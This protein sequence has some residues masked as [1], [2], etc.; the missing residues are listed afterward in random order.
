MLVVVPVCNPIYV[1]G[2]GRRNP[3]SVGEKVRPLVKK[4]KTKATRAG[5]VAQVVKHLSSKANAQSLNSGI[6]KSRNKTNEQ[7]ILAFL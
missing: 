5:G 2:I 3:R 7:K 6:I 1:G 4:K